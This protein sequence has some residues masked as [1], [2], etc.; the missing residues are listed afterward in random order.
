MAGESGFDAGWI[1]AFK[2]N[3]SPLVDIILR[4]SE[5]PL[6]LPFRHPLPIRSN[7]FYIYPPPQRRIPKLPPTRLTPAWLPPP[8]SSLYNFAN[9]VFT[10][11]L[12]CL[13]HVAP[14]ESSAAPRAAG[15]LPLLPLCE[16]RRRRIII[17]KDA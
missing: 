6:T 14:T 9:V 5:T 12:F 4:K 15:A 16:R 7:Q 17:N 11:C 10:F 3:R 2:E 8:D 1:S 13:I